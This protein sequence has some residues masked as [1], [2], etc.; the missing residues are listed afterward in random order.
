MEWYHIFMS[1]Y[2]ALISLGALRSESCTGLIV[3]IIM[4]FL[5]IHA[6]NSGGFWV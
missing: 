6:L 2:I 1:I 4:I 5:L 3:Y